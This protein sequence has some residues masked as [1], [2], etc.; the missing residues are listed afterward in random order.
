MKLYIDDL[1]DPKEELGEGRAVGMVWIKEYWEAQRFLLEN[2]AELTEIH[3]DHYL[4]GTHT[5]GELVMMVAYR[6]LMKVAFKK[7]TDI[8]LHSSDESI[9]EDI[10]EEVGERLAAVGVTVHNNSRG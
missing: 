8:Y 1:R 2:E 6:R 5:G 4:A 7:L 3:F 10:I 9:V